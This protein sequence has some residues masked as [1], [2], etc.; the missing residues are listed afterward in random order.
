MRAACF[1]ACES[2]PTAFASGSAGVI[3]HACVRGHARMHARART[4]RRRRQLYFYFY[5]VP[6]A[7][8]DIC[9]LEDG[10]CDVV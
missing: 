10:G 8:A 9:A 3:L 5:F 1:N 7:A 4:A 2:G 6:R